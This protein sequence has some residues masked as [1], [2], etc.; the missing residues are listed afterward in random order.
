[1]RFSG[2]WNLLGNED[3]RTSREA[4]LR[5]IGDVAHEGRDALAGRATD[6]LV[7]LRHAIATSLRVLNVALTDGV[8][9]GR[10]HGILA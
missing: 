5:V 9:Q 10:D 1:M 2:A 6:I 4:E 7:A 8:R 3:A